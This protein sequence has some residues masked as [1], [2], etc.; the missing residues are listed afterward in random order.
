M[1]LQNAIKQA[2]ERK[3]AAEAA[4][5]KAIQD[6]VLAKQKAMKEAAIAKIQAQQKAI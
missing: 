3:K 6:A 2:A 4:K 1:A 5:K